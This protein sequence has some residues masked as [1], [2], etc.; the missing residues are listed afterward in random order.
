MYNANKKDVGNIFSIQNCSVKINIMLS[1]TR[2]IKGG[3]FLGGGGG[4]YFP[5]PYKTGWVPSR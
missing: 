5:L 2:E 3:I 1:L 4:G